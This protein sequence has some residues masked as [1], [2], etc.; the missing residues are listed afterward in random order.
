MAIWIGSN[1][2][3]GSSIPLP[4]GGAMP[5][6]RP[7][8]APPPVP[9][10]LTLGM[11]RTSMPS[12][13]GVQ[14]SRIAAQPCSS[15][16]AKRWQLTRGDLPTHRLPRP[17]RCHMTTEAIGQVKCLC[18]LGQCSTFRPPNHRRSRR[19][20]AH[21]SQFHPSWRTCRLRAASS[22]CIVR[23]PSCQPVLTLH[24]RHRRCLMPAPHL[25]ATLSKPRRSMCRLGGSR[26]AP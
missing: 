22:R 26:C 19:A 12:T 5:L 9:C 14:P 6:R 17:C 18:R 3:T 24:D 10:R 7:C 8:R 15:L 23:F 21:L 25:R 2:D 1:R 13:R 11:P 16:S 4:C 20:R